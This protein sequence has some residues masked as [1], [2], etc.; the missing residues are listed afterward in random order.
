MGFDRDISHWQGLI[1]PKGL[2]QEVLNKLASVVKEIVESPE[3]AA[4]LIKMRTN[5]EWM[6]PEQF[7]AFF[8]KEFDMYGEVLNTLVQK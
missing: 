5:A 3:F 8:E 2:P 7:K 6:G 4:E 1:A